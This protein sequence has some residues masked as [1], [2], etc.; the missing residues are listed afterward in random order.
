MARRSSQSI[1]TAPVLCYI[2][3]FLRRSLRSNLRLLLFMGTMLTSASCFA[4]SVPPP[5][6]GGAC[7]NAPVPDVTNFDHPANLSTIMVDG[8]PFSLV[9]GNKPW[10]IANPDSQTLRFEV[11][12][13]DCFEQPG[14]GYCENN[15]THSERSEVV[16]PATANRDNLPYGQEINVSY[17]ITIE[18]G[19]ANTAAWFAI[20]QFH[21]QDP[22]GEGTSPPLE[23]DLQPGDHMSIYVGWLT[24][25]HA[26]VS[27]LY[28]TTKGNLNVSYGQV[29]MDPNDIVRGHNYA[30]CLQIKF[31]SVNGYARVW[32]DGVQIVNYTGPLGFGQPVYW[33]MGIYRGTTTNDVQAADY[34]NFVIG[35]GGDCA[36]VSG[37]GGA[38][39]CVPRSRLHRVRA[40]Y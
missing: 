2:P 39:L 19:Q 14:S 37:G 38:T 36:P 22:N 12:S 8:K 24:G 5:A 15:P 23:I 3:T 16:Y 21:N 11:H 40:G 32:R 31:D 34:Q 28:S 4:A 17:N 29:Y 35:T 13:G 9:N 26:P 6:P 10:S 20:G 1:K 18:P 27:M 30:M 33:K 25:L 7:C